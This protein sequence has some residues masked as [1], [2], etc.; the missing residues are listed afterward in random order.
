LGSRHHDGC[1]ARRIAELVPCV[2]AGVRSLSRQEA[3][4][5][6]RL[7]API[8]YD[9]ERHRDGQW[10]AH[11]LPRLADEVYVSVD[12]GVFDP[13]VMP[14]SAL[15]EPGGLLWRDAIALLRRV[16]EER[17]VVACDLVGHSALPGAVAP[18]FM[19]A[20]LAY[21]MMTY[22]CSIGRGARAPALPRGSQAKS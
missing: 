13:S 11:L 17:S 15:P 18:T 3:E 4:D 20:K 7:N 6:R 1:S 8:V 21:K 5:A 2:L 22:A 12:S 16:F 14:S 19:C 9:Y 10:I